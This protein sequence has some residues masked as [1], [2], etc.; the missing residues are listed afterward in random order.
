MVQVESYCISKGNVIEKENTARCHEMETT[1]ADLLL[2][3]MGT[4]HMSHHVDSIP[5]VEFIL[6]TGLGCIDTTLAIL[7]HQP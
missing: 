1:I 2:T 7:A 5:A 4:E 3:D 6:K